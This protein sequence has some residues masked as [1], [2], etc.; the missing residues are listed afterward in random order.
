MG[1]QLP[2]RLR[3]RA[4]VRFAVRLQLPSQLQPERLVVGGVGGL[5]LQ[6]HVVGAAFA[7]SW[8]SGMVSAPQLHM[9]LF[10]FSSVTA[11]LSFRLP[12]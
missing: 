1:L 8:K 10:S 11:M 2:V 4:Q 3:L 7:L 9:V 5:V 12:A 6:Q